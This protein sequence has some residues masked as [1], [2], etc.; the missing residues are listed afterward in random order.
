MKKNLVPEI[1]GNLRN[2]FL[3][4][5]SEINQ[6]N[7]I[8]I[9]GKNIKSIV[10]STDV[11]IIKNVNADA[12]LAVYPFTPQP[13][14]NQAVIMTADVPVFSGVGGCHTFDK[15]RVLNLAL[16][17]EFQGAI[18]VV[19]NATV[20][21]ELIESVAQKIDIPVVVTIASNKDDITG[22]IDAGALILNVSASI[23]TPFVVD[24]I[25]SRYPNIAVM[26][27]GGPTS[28][29]VIDTINAGA[30]AITWTPPTTGELFKPTMTYCRNQFGI[31]KYETMISSKDE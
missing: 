12:V 23:D 15:N 19:L 2:N 30:D 16:H 31:G 20:S 7:G 1:K 8:K 3:E 11:A 24:K 21:N 5:P 4:V 17:A 9:F 28:Q 13:I 27:T 10:F 25:K 29:T 14:I 22:R 18:G 6:V 26:A